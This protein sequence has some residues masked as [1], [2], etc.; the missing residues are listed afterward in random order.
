M[1]AKLDAAS[2][3]PSPEA[4]RLTLLKRITHDLTG[5]AP[6]P[7]EIAAFLADR[8]PEAYEEGGGSAACEPSLR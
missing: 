7:E 6:T 5:L 8:S 2:L 3:R 4:D 1:L